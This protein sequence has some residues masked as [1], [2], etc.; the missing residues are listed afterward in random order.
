[1]KLLRKRDESCPAELLAVGLAPFP[2]NKSLKSNSLC[3]F[4]RVLSARPCFWE[5]NWV[6]LSK[7]EQENSPN[8]TL[9]A[10]GK[11]SQGNF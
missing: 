10:G 1:M 2:G 5:A 8:L 6:K 11:L 3:S 9:T 7:R 4:N